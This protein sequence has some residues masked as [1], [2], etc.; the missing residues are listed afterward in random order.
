MTAI[1][2]G[3]EPG[4]QRGRSAHMV[5]AAPV[6]PHAGTSSCTRSEARRLILAALDGAT[7]TPDAVELARTLQ[8]TSGHR[9]A[10]VVVLQILRELRTDGLVEGQGF[11]GR[12]AGWRLT[13]SPRAAAEAEV[14]ATL[15][16]RGGTT[17]GALLAFATGLPAPA[18]RQLLVGMEAAGLLTSQ[19]APGRVTTWRLV[20]PAP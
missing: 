7:G 9:V 15:K 2:A 13:V 12:N 8:R 11:I 18:C 10:P 14:I 20:E 19:R 5:R 4:D 6:R 1:P 16:R 17:S 3:K